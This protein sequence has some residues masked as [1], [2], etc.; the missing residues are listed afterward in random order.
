MNRTD[1]IL[2]MKCDSEVVNRG[3]GSSSGQCSCS[4]GWLGP[5]CQVEMLDPNNIANRG[6]LPEDWEW[7]TKR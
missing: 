4:P 6:D 7:R 1:K 5:T 2:H 3:S